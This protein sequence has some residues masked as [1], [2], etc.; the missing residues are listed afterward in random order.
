MNSR[1][2]DIAERFTRL[3]ADRR[4]AFLALLREQGIA[5]DR[6]PIVPWPAGDEPDPMSPAQARQWFLW[7]LD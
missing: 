4:S 7:R 1:A 6:L 2:R 3:P 5:F